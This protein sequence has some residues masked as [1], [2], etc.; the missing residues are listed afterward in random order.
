MSLW[1]SR[2]PPKPRRQRSRRSRTL[3]RSAKENAAEISVLEGTHLRPTRSNG[4]WAPLQNLAVG[5]PAEARTHVGPLISR[6]A[7]DRVAAAVD[8]ARSVGAHILHARLD[9]LPQRAGGHLRQPQESPEVRCCA[10]RPPAGP[11]ERDR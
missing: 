11:G 9:G 4:S 5:D 6:A 1:P 2:L 8:A 7:F 3:C 10:R